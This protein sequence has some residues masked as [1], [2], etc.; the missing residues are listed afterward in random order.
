M[1]SNFPPDMEQL[2]ENRSEISDLVQQHRPWLVRLIA[3]RCDEGMADDIIQE[4]NLAV[5]RSAETPESESGIRSWLCTIALRQCA[6][7]IRKSVRQRRL[8]N[9]VADHQRTHDGEQSDPLLW[10]MRS[11]HATLIRKALT[12]LDD[13]SRS[14]LLLKYQAG[15]T[16]AQIAEERAIAPHQVEYKIMKARQQLHQKLV[17]LGIDTEVSQ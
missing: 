9:N 7:S 14:M 8:L 16:Y 3:S 6:L 13:D 15:K 4:V 12:Q 10:M 1:P 2:T 5:V 17:S 11:E